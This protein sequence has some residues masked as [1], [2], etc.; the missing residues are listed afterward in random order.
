[1]AKLSFISDET[2]RIELDE[3]TW[4]EV[5][6]Q[7]SYEEYLSVLGDFKEESSNAEKA[8]V[9][10]KLLQKVVVAWSEASVEC[11]PENIKKL[12]IPTV[13]AIVGRVMEIYNP[14]KKS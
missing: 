13:N 4:V 14:E 8:G 11:T 9:A 12:D 2:E 5:K 10:I 3:G 7:I 1:M 6:K